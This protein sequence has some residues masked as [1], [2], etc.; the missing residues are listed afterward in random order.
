MNTTIDTTAQKTLT[1]DHK[2]GHS[3]TYKLIDGGKD[4]PIAYYIDTPDNLIGTLERIRT[5]KIRV[6]FMWGDK[7]TGKSWNEEHDT[8]GTIG[9][10]KGKDAY[11]PILIHNANSTGGG[12]ILTDRILKINATKSKQVLY[13]HPN[14][15]PSLIE[16]VQPIPTALHQLI[17]DGVLYSQHDTFRKAYLLKNKLS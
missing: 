9:L 16:I 1:I 17:I 14:Y 10:S 5:N 13:T 7:D 12:M 6:K 2:N 3:S 4:K 8:M 11:F 15:K